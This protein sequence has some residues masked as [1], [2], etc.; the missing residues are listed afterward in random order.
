MRYVVILALVLLVALTGGTFAAAPVTPT[1]SSLTISAVRLTVGARSAT[2]HWTTS[3]SAGG[4]VFY[5][6]ADGAW[7]DSV[8]S[9][10]DGFSHTATLPDLVPS[11]TYRFW[12]TAYRA[13]GTNAFSLPAEF[14]TAAAPA[15]P[16]PADLGAPSALIV[17]ASGL[18]VSDDFNRTG[19][20]GPWTFVNP[21]GDAAYVLTGTD[22]RLIVPDGALH[23]PWTSGN[24]AV[25]LLQ[26]SADADFDVVAKFNS[27]V[28]GHIAMQGLIAQ[29]SNTDYVRFDISS[30][31]NQAGVEQ[32][33]LYAGRV[34]GGSATTFAFSVLANPGHPTWLRLTRSGTTWT[35]RYS[36]D[37]VMWTTLTT[38][39][40]TLSLTSVGVFA[41]NA[42]PSG[43]YAQPFTA[44]VDYFHV[45]DAP[46]ADDPVAHADGHAPLLVCPPHRLSGTTLDVTGFSDEPTTAEL[47]YGS[48]TATGG[49]LTRG[50]GQTHSFSV[51]GLQPATTYWYR[52]T[53]S[54][55]S[56]RTAACSGMVRVR[57]TAVGSAPVIDVWGGAVQTF[58]ARGNP[59]RWVNVLGEVSD[60]DGFAVNIATFG[61]SAWPLR[62][63]LNGGAERSL[64]L[65]PGYY[66]NNMLNW[67][68]VYNAGEFNIE[69]DRSEL[70]PGENTLVITAVDRLGN[71]SE[72]TV[73][74]RYVAG[75]TWPLPYAIAW[76][77]VERVEEA[78][79]AVD[80]L[81][82]L[83]EGGVRPVWTG[84]DRLL[85]IGDATWT[86][87][88]VTVPIT[89]H[90][91]DMY[92]GQRPNSGGP[93]VGLLL[94]WQGHWDAAEA[95]ATQPRW[96]YYP[97]GALG[98]YR[99]E[100]YPESSSTQRIMHLHLDTGAAT[101]FARDLSGMRL[102]VGKTYLFKMRVE[103]GA[104]YRLKVWEA[105]SAE[106][107][108]W[109]VEGE[110]PAGEQTAGGGVGA[111]GGAPRR[112]QF[113]QRYHTTYR[114]FWRTD[115]D[116]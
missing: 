23:E 10:G 83:E 47:R 35:F 110:A 67:R 7:S 57:P 71:M 102:E 88:E 62:Y 29:A 113:W 66:E 107:A 50:V 99:L 44:A 105:E 15:T 73:T 41:G 84:Y 80:G 49:T 13:D 9:N 21:R 24:T 20:L 56:G 106:P 30:A 19:G 92:R 77:T 39:T 18:L 78:A 103:G 51:S 14:T 22:L 70:N 3:L 87:Y 89:I 46:L 4:A 31:R 17:P 32:V 5:G 43:R 59:Q 16:S 115:G 101:V 48:R 97:L 36:F 111:A 64:M 45:A 72:Q 53:V 55:G 93:G 74:L 34:N 63:R 86:D 33:R 98:W 75:Q 95:L 6:P 11:T 82:G 68:R 85:A 25:R 26:P 69:L 1:P 109:T 28:S 38:A 37:G 94:R 90:E 60:A 81:W 116:P 40:V 12:I 112:C 58:G 61:T 65:G 2:V 100:R 104:R 27:R 42:E 76:E 79:Q 52:L 108:G 91:I 8:P 96:V 114:R 54:D